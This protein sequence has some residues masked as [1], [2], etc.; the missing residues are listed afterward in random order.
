MT[1]DSLRS[2]RSN[3]LLILP[4]PAGTILLYAADGLSSWR[5]HLSPEGTPRTPS[6]S[7]WVP[8][9]R[10][11]VD[12]KEGLLTLHDLAKAGMRAWNCPPPMVGCLD[13]AFRDITF[14]AMSI[15]ALQHFADTAPERVM[16]PGAEPSP[17]P[18]SPKIQPRPERA[19]QNPPATSP[20]RP[21]PR[22]GGGGIKPALH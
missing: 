14:R 22:P 8:M 21:R 16:L 12:S 6:R 1:R 9:F 4:P 5:G 13:D 18:P 19:R 10:Q 15:A 17:Y 2:G 7:H 3:K 20:H 11:L